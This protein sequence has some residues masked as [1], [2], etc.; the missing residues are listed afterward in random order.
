MRITVIFEVYKYVEV[1]YI[2]IRSQ[3]QEGED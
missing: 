1:T 3:K 2:W